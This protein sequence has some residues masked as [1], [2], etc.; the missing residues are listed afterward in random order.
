VS[1][2]VDLKAL[3]NNVRFGDSLMF[4]LFDNAACTGE[5]VYSE[6]LAAGSS[7]V[8]VEEVQPVALKKQSPKPDRVARV[9]STLGM[10]VVGTA[11]YL[12]TVGNGIEPAGEACQVEFPDSRGRLRAFGNLP[13]AGF[14]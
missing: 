3:R 1:Y 6:L 12:L 14:S 8:T 13:E 10:D 9:H 4:S 11:L 2:D 5:A 7:R